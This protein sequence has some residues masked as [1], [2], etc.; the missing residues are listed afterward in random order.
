MELAEF[1]P[2]IVKRLG[3]FERRGRGKVV[4]FSQGEPAAEPA[5]R[6]APRPAEAKAPELPMKLEPLKV[7]ELPMKSELL[8]LAELPMKSELSR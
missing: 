3:V 5:K 6:M 8:R 4:A 2:G 1:T 7:L